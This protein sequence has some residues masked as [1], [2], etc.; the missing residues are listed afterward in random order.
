VS[1]VYIDGQPEVVGSLP[2]TPHRD[3]GRSDVVVGL[4]IRRLEAHNLMK[5]LGFRQ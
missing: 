4:R 5:D 1:R 2:V 3:Q